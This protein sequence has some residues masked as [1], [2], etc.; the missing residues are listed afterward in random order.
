V[1]PGKPLVTPANVGIPGK[2][3]HHAA[4]LLALPVVL[5]IF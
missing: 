1:Q 5:T 3:R 4:L 2:L